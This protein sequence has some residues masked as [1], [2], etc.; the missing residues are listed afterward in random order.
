MWEDQNGFV[1]IEHFDTEKEFDDY[2]ARA[3]GTA[4]EDDD[5]EDDEE[6]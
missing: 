3:E 6:Y 5:D 2:V 4:D 1:S